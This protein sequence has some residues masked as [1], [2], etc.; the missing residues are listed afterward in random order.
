[1]YNKSNEKTLFITLI[2]EK[3]NTASTSFFYWLLEV[4]NSTF[5]PLFLLQITFRFSLCPSRIPK[6]YSFQSVWILCQLW[7]YTV[8]WSLQ[9]KNIMWSVLW[10]WWDT[11]VTHFNHCRSVFGVQFWCSHFMWILPD[12]VAL[13]SLGPLGSSLPFFSVFCFCFCFF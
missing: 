8:S 11:F 5:R 3:I 4:E 12:W 7:S 13:L 2:I 10:G 1:M 6:L 9:E